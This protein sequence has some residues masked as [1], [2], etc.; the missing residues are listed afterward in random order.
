MTASEQI[1][2]PSKP[3]PG[4]V[5]NKQR[6]NAPSTAGHPSHHNA[7]IIT[8]ANGYAILLEPRPDQ[9]IDI[10][11]T[12]SLTPRCGLSPRAG[13]QGLP[14]GIGLDSADITRRSNCA[15]WHRN[16]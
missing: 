14:R 3:A 1:P 13:L 4:R 7:K 2:W 12:E 9:C 8:S 6:A 15:G 16:S 5:A 11:M 10:E